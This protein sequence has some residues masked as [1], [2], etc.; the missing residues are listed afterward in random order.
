MGLY[1]E[2]NGEVTLLLQKLDSGAVLSSEDCQFLQD[3]GLFGLAAYARHHASTGA[4]DRRLLQTP[5]DRRR[6]AAAERRTLREKYEIEYVDAKHLHKLYALLRRID[7]QQRLTDEDCRWLISIDMFTKP[8]RNAFHHNEA[9]HHK[10][11]FERTGNPR[12]AVNANSHFRKANEASAGL[13]LLD[14]IDVASQHDARLRS[15]LWTTKGGSLRDMGRHAEA[16]HAA[17]AGHSADNCSFHPCTLL[18]A[19]HYE[20]GNR[21]EGDA[22]F[23]KAVER[24]ASNEVVD[25]E[26]QIIWRRSNKA[27]RA[28]MRAHL[29]ALDPHRYAWVRQTVLTRGRH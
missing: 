5:E 18:G 26:L 1:T 6:R 13:A 28:G 25:H 21:S 7:T 24:G 15:A 29:L 17:M 23:A 11:I 8:L 19:L 3:K 2:A 10:A 16:M 12:H 22:W 9:L 27:Q 14:G 4:H 20:I